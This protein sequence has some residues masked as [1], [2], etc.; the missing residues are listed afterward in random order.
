YFNE[1][2]VRYDAAIRPNYNSSTQTTNPTA[3][4]EIFTSERFY[5]HLNFFGKLKKSFNYDVS[6]SYQQQKR[7]VEAYNYRIKTREKFDVEEF[8]YESRDV[9]YSKGTFSNFFESKYF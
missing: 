9:L 7:N 3:S 5:H 8:E 1:N 6:F 4:D 2:I